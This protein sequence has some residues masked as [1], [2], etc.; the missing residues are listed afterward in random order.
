VKGGDW[1]GEEGMNQPVQALKR[2]WYKLRNKGSLD[3]PIIPAPVPG[4]LRR[5]GNAG[6]ASKADGQW[7]TFVERQRELLS[8]IFCSLFA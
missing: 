8:R 2:G 7:F 1:V 4:E 6:K 3:Q 5:D